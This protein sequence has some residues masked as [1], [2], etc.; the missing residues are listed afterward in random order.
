M[1]DI[2]SVLLHHSIQALSCLLYSCTHLTLCYCWLYGGED[3][4]TFVFFHAKLFFLE[5]FLP[6]L[7]LSLAV[8]ALVSYLSSDSGDEISARAFCIH[9]ILSSRK[10]LCLQFLLVKSRSHIRPC[11]NQLS[12]YVTYRNICFLGE[13]FR[14]IAYVQS[15]RTGFLK[16]ILKYF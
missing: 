6:Y 1:V 4:R 5:I 14:I 16:I 8:T 3:A 9:R 2:F 15:V 11:W 7:Q 10:Y 13:S 12:T